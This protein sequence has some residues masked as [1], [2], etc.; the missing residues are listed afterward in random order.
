MDIR[1]ALSEVLEQYG[2]DE[3]KSSWKTVQPLLMELCI[4]RPL[5]YM[6]YLH[7]RRICNCLPL[8]EYF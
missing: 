4:G 3:G 5:T 8:V 7:K 6:A 2:S 1:N